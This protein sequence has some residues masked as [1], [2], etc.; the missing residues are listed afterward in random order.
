VGNSK[1]NIVVQ[2]P[3]NMAETRIRKSAHRKP[4]HIELSMFPD[5]VLELALELVKRK[6]DS[7]V[8][9]CP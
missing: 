3:N 5:E 7:T 2:K 4:K 9:D 8:V 6:R 1:Q